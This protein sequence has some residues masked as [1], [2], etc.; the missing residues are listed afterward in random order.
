MIRQ[1]RAQRVTIIAHRGVHNS[2]ADENT[3]ASF[4][5]AL[6]NDGVDGVECDVRY[7]KDKA[8]VIAHDNDLAFRGHRDRYVSNMDAEQLASAPYLIP[9]L[10]SVF[11]TFSHNMEKKLV[12]DYKTQ[13]GTLDAIQQ[14]EAW[15]AQYNCNIMHLVWQD[16]YDFVQG[17]QPKHPV[18]YALDDDESQDI[19]CD[20]LMRKGYAGVSLK[21]GDRRVDQVLESNHLIVNLYGPHSQR[22]AMLGLAVDDPGKF[23]ITVDIPVPLQF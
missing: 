12:I 21:Y 11:E 10:E 3:L 15:A 5:L 7:S 17:H 13:H 23:I 22:E 9:R 19:D 14:A 16:D 18:Y 1:P 20:A 4:E 6:T 8:L 2:R